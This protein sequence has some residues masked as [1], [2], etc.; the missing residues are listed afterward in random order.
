MSTEKHLWDLNRLHTFVEVAR[1]GSLKAASLKLGMAQPAISRQMA[2]LESECKGRLFERTGRG[3]VLTELGSRMLPMVER[4]LGQADELTESVASTAGVPFGDVRIGMLPSLYRHIGVPLFFAARKSYPGVRLQFFEGSAGQIDQW[5][6]LGNLDIGLPYRYESNSGPEGDPII[7]ADSCL[8]GPGGD[9]L[10]SRDSVPFKTLH[11]LPLILPSAPSG[12]RSTLDR[13]ARQQGIELNIV[14]EA[15]S[16]QLQTT[17]VAKGGAYTVLPELAITDYLAR[18]E[19]QAARI[20]DP[21]IERRVTLVLSS[22][23]PPSY[24]AR[25][26][27]KLMREIVE[28]SPILRTNRKGA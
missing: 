24:A 1:S 4:M 16:T 8:V 12:V 27:A 28:N 3:M 9:R 26:I 21:V 5:L 2:R 23:H 7:S 14:V 6:G 15:D 20:V 11:E 17:I 19:L 13:L 22:A 18:G 25:C 10:T